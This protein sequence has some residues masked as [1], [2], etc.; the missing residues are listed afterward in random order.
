MPQMSHEG[1][2]GNKGQRKRKKI[3]A[4]VNEK[5]ERYAARQV[6][7]TGQSGFEKAPKGYAI[8]RSPTSQSRIVEGCCVKAR[9]M[10]KVSRNKETYSPP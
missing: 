6:Q 7:R 8:L 9:K 2:N 10:L 1:V 4:G 3:K 5:N